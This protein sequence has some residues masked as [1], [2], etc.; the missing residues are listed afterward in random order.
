MVDRPARPERFLA[1]DPA[2]TSGFAHGLGGGRPIGG[3]IKLP[4][5]HHR[6][7]RFC[8]LEGAVREII[9][10]SEVTRIVVERLYIKPYYSEPDDL[11][12]ATPPNDEEVE[13]AI[14]AYK[15]AFAAEKSVIERMR[16]A[17]MAVLRFRNF[18][19]REDKGRLTFSMDQ[20]MLSIGYQTAI[21]MAAQKE[22]LGEAIDYAT[23]GQWRSA[24]GVPSAPKEM[25]RYENRRKFLK[26]HAVM[27]CRELGWLPQTDDVAEAMGLWYWAERKYSQE[28]ANERLPLF[29]KVEL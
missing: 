25:K 11:P 20:I 10:V 18:A 6:P 28:H 5:S 21:V 23:P 16:A 26:Q 12:N 24:L 7:N 29:N 17:V 1:L 14:A 19:P 8:L 4:D 2:T 27:R 13:R 22:G 9:R 3:I 15:T